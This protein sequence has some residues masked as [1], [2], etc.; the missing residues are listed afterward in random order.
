MKNNIRYSPEAEADLDQ[1]WDY[2]LSELGSPQAAE[3]TVTQILDTV[4]SLEDFPKLGTPLA[5][6]T[7]I[8]SDYRFLLSGSYIAFYRIENDTIY[9]DR[10]LHEK[11]DFLRIL[12][13]DFQ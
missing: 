9:M 6:V 3:R 12:F 11:Q 5:A 4:D 10:I 8:E 13:S 1:I 7:N 2:L